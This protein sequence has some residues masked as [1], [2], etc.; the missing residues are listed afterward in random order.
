MSQKYGDCIDP[1]LKSAMEDFRKTMS[2]LHQSNVARTYR[3]SGQYAHYVAYLAARPEL[4]WRLFSRAV[5]RSEN[6][7]SGAVLR[8]RSSP[9]IMR[10]HPPDLSKGDAAQVQAAKD[11]ATMM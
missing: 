9:K 11:L 4:A 7:W 5:M 8:L 10:T 2:L 3:R 6:E 1:T